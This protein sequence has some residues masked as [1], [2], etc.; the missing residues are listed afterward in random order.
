MAPEYIALNPNGTIPTLVVVE[1]NGTRRILT[2]SR[3]ILALAVSHS[4]SLRGPK[5]AE[6]FVERFYN[7]DLSYFY[8]AVAS[9]SDAVREMTVGKWRKR[10]EV[11]Q[12]EAEKTADEGLKKAY[13]EKAETVRWLFDAWGR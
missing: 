12:A 1:E 4:P 13:L 11:A 10:A 8:A 9:A 6:E 3:D 2:E 5:K 7:G